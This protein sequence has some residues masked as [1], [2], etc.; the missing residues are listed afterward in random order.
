M[1]TLLTKKKICVDGIELSQ[2]RARAFTLIELL[3]VIAIIGILAALLLPVLAKAKDKAHQTTC[4]NNLRQLGIAF[5]LYWGDFSDHFPAPGSK[6]IYGPKPEDWI[7]WQYGREVNNSAIAKF[8]GN[9]NPTLFTCPAD[10]TA[11]SFQT[12]GNVVG[13]PYRYSYSLTSYDLTN[14]VNPGMSTIIDWDG[15]VFPF[16]AASIRNPSAKI[17][18]VEESS[19]TIDDSRWVPNANWISSRHGGKGDITFADGHVE[20]ETPQFGKDPINS[21]PTY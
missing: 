16:K 17:M 2:N 13:D 11:L 18:L 6:N 5:Q 12:Q 3:V 9:F 8:V 19:K 14:N 20:R 1:P 15:N 4:F 21:N 10:R 7:W